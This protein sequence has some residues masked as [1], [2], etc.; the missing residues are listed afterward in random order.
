METDRNRGKI[1]HTRRIEGDVTIFWPTPLALR[2]SDIHDTPRGSLVV[3]F[4]FAVRLKLDYLVRFLRYCRCRHQCMVT[5]SATRQYLFQWGRRKCVHIL[6]LF[7]LA[8]STGCSVFS[9]LL[10]HLV[11]CAFSIILIEPS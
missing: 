8:R 9:K 11:T 5:L 10:F 4:V 7:H 2:L 1:K 6:I 3:I